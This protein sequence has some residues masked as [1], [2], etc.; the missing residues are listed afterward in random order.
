V[1]RAVG[2]LDATL[3]EV[4][5]TL[6]EVSTLIVETSE[7]RINRDAK[8]WRVIGRRRDDLHGQ[9]GEVGFSTSTGRSSEPEW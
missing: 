7:M 2:V 9:R 8:H 3:G 1:A 5:K 4:S 6:A